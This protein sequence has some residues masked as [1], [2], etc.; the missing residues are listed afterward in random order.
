MLILHVDNQIK[1]QKMGVYF[2]L[3]KNRVQNIK[4]TMAKSTVFPSEI[5]DLYC[6]S[7]STIFYI[8]RNGIKKKI[9]PQSLVKKSGYVSGKDV[10]EVLE[11]LGMPNDKY[12]NALLKVDICEAYG[13]NY[14]LLQ[15]YVSKSKLDEEFKQKIYHTKIL[16]PA[17]LEKIENEFGEPNIPFK[18]MCQK[19]REKYLKR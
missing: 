9:F 1:I 8:I 18:E 7:R 10:S 13:M 17:D 5:H 6:V 16:F 19:R 4:K 2:Q 12:P 11:Y 3:L 15:F 14:Q